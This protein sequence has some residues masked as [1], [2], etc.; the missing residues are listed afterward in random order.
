MYQY[1]PNKQQIWLGL[2]LS[3]CKNVIASLNQWSKRHE[4]VLAVLAG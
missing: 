3:I 1:T 4:L 2:L